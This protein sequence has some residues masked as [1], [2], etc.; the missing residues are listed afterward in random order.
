MKS[1][2]KYLIIPKLQVAPRTNARARGLELLVKGT[3][4]NL[5]VAPRTNAPR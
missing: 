5:E 3:I 1:L 4:P 2:D